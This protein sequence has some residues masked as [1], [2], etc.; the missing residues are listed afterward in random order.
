[1]RHPH[2]F[3]V[4]NDYGEQLLS[5]HLSD[6]LR[7][8]VLD[9]VERLAT[10]EDVRFVEERIAAAGVDGV[11]FLRDLERSSP[12][13]VAYT[14]ELWELLRELEAPAP[15]QRGDGGG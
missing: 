4:V 7:L 2:E 14:P 8:P 11:R 9:Q 3:C 6:G 12:Y 13:G 10:P 15:S 1:M 5:G